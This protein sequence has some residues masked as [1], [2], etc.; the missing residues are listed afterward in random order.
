[1]GWLEQQLKDARIV[2]FIWDRLTELEGVDP[3]AVD[4]GRDALD[5]CCEKVDVTGNDGEPRYL[6]GPVNNMKPLR[7]LA[8]NWADHPDFD[9]EWAT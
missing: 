8:R 4:L 2:T 3:E 7:R 9:T 5:A 1:M 6:R